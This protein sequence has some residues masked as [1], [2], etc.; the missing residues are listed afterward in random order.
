[1]LGTSYIHT[2]NELRR[3]QAVLNIQNLDDNYCILCA[4]LA[5]IHP[6]ERNS[7]PELPQMYSKFMAELNYEELEFPLKINA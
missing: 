3:K 4:I 1:M 7:H 5:H 6:V 2:P